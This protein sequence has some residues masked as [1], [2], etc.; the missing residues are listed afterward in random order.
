MPSK[1]ETINNTYFSDKGYGAI[2]TLFRDA[3]KKDPSI[4]FGDVKSWVSKNI[5]RTKNYKFQ[6]SWVPK[7]PLEEL[8]IDVFWYK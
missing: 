5:V 3:K 6:N 1:E 2:S 8:Q 4:S 7:G